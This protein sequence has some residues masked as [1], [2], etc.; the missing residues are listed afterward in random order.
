MSSNSTLRTRQLN[1]MAE[2]MGRHY[3]HRE[4]PVVA[5]ITGESGSGKSLLARQL[6]SELESRYAKDVAV[7]D[8]V[9]P[10]DADELLRKLEI[11]R[12][13][14]E[15]VEL[16]GR[17]LGFF[18]AA[19]YRNVT[20]DMLPVFIIV[21]FAGAYDR[22]DSLPGGARDRIMAVASV[23]AQMQ[24]GEARLWIKPSD[25]HG[26]DVAT[27]VTELDRRH[28]LSEQIDDALVD[29]PEVTDGERFVIALG[30]TLRL[31]GDLY[32]S[33]DLADEWPS[34]DRVIAALL[35]MAHNE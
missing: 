3:R 5:V 18:E 31:L 32:G 2:E 22:V 14:P 16:D 7:F 8:D 24:G 33:G 11:L 1:E 28:H 27:F 6:R 17:G 4:T 21:V 34:A 19:K 23:V 12:W 30:E 35:A 29:F 10:D 9:D 26:D 15:Q 13:H 20:K 25:A